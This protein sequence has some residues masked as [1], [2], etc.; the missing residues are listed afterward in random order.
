MSRV[1]VVPSPSWPSSLAPQQRTVASGAIAHACRAPLATCSVSRTGQASPACIEHATR[2]APKY[3]TGA[4]QG[5]RSRPCRRWQDGSSFG[6]HEH[7]PLRGLAGVPPRPQPQ[8][9]RYAEA[10]GTARVRQDGDRRDRPLLAQDDVDEVR[11]GGRS[12][13]G[14]YQRIAVDEKQTAAGTS[15]SDGVCGVGDPG[16]HQYGRSD[17]RGTYATAGLDG[18]PPS[19]VEAERSILMTVDDTQSCGMS[20]RLRAFE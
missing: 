12:L 19:R 18:K 11:H 5:C 10:G 6:V 20:G 7:H 8:T 17:A 3:R 9:E 14:V 1:V 13:S 2:L 15:G 16:E 4:R